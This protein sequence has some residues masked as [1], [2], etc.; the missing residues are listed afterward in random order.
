MTT[1][2]NLSRCGYSHL[3]K[4]ALITFLREPFIPRQVCTK[5]EYLREKKACPSCGKEVS[6][7]NWYRHQAIHVRQ[8]LSEFTHFDNDLFN[9]DNTSLRESLVIKESA[10]ALNGFIKE[11]KVKPQKTYDPHAFFQEAKEAI[12]NLFRLNPSTKVMMF[13]C[14]SMV[15]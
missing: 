3:Q 8:G 11:Y 4:G 9:Q 15:K 13:L 5:N 7:R 6:H 12:T 1:V 2:S 14:G 10:S